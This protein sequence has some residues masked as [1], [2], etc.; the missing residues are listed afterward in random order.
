[1]QRILFSLVG[2]LF[3][4]IPFSVIFHLIFKTADPRNAGSRN[5][6]ATN[7][8]RVAGKK[9]AAITLFCDALKGAIPVVLYMC[10]NDLYH[11]D[12]FEIAADNIVLHIA[13]FA[14][15]GHI[16]PVWLKFKGG[17]GVATALGVYGAMSPFLFSIAAVT[18]LV[19]FGL[20]KTSSIAAL[21]SL[22]CA[23]PLYIGYLSLSST[24]VTNMFLFSVLIA[25]ILALTHIK[26]IKRIIEGT[27]PKTR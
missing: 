27:E 5:V 11:R 23:V 16:F 20:S 14:I 19:T 6:G 17:K 12:F 26:N 10:Y 24:A 13:F 25:V 2:Y 18:W 9:V 21:V 1:M 15:T 4:S 7:M 22:C 3:G 8:L